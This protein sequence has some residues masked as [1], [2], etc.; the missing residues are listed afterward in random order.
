M[1]DASA[2]ATAGVTG[3]VTLQRSESVEGVRV[4]AI[5]WEAGSSNEKDLKAKEQRNEAQTLVD[6]VTR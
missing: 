3:G 1:T 4:L 2:L 6:A 5:E